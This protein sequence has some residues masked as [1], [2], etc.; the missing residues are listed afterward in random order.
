MTEIPE[1]AVQAA[2]AAHRHALLD[3]PDPLA[4]PD[5]DLFRLVLE[6]ALPHLAPRA[7]PYRGPVEA[8]RLPCGERLGADGRS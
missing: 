8:G 5:E 6:A 3:R 1:A 4:L 2:I 7:G